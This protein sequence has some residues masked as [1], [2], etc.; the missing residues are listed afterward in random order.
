MVAFQVLK[1]GPEGLPD[2]SVL[3]HNVVI[4]KKNLNFQ[5]STINLALFLLRMAD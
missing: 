1:D 5:F 3:L 2:L 4:L